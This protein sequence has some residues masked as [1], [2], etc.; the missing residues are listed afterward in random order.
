MPRKTQYD[1]RALAA[2]LRKQHGVITREQAQACGMSRP[3]VNH[4]VRAGGPWPRL[5]PGVHLTHTG[6]ATDDQRDMGALLYA[7]PRGVLTGAAALRRFGIAVPRAKA[8][9]VLVPVGTQKRDAGFVRLHRTTRLPELVGVAGKIQYALPQRAVADAARCLGDL[10]DVRALV[11][12]AVQRNKCSVQHLA[13][14]LT[15]GPMRGS[16]LFRRALAE[17]ADGARSA[18]EADLHSV[19]GSAR[20]PTPMYNPSLFVG[21]DFLARP[22]CW[23]PEAGVA[24]EVDSRAWHLSPRDWERTLARHVR[25]SALGIIVLHFTPGQIRSKRPD[26]VA[27]IRDAIAA[28]QGRP[29]PRIRAV[30]AS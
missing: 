7:G 28:G 27:A 19:I 13:D 4:R 16:A 2:L 22:D 26:V 21:R 24:V 1:E 10:G 5:L 8:V 15:S 29:L 18:A 14:E 30:P 11:A 3:M 6:T 25:M 20:L 12:S 9:D 17:V 23:W